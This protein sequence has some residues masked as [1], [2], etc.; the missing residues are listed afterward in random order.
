M[1]SLRGYIGSVVQWI[2][3]EIP[4]LTIAV[5]IRS[6]SQEIERTTE[7]E[8]RKTESGQREISEFSEISVG[9]P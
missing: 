2:E 8:Q 4:V 5:R 6:E 3:F 7:N 1:L 9:C